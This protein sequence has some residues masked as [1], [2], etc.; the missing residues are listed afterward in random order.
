MMYTILM[1][2]LATM[3]GLT[4]LFFWAACRVETEAEG[5]SSKKKGGQINAY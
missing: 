3:A 1:W 4:T 5:Q 2:L